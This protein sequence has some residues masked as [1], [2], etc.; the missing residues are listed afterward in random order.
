MVKEKII[1]ETKEQKFKRIA[2]ARTR[3]ILH[4]LR[5]LGNCA[6]RNTY[7]YTNNDVEKIF[8]TIERQLKETKSKFYV[9]RNEEF[10]L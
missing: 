8:G 3:K 10:T 6:N 7:E 2:S 9:R 4:S 1:N 5:L